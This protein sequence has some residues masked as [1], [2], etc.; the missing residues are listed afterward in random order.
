MGHRLAFKLSLP[1][2]IMQLWYNGIVTAMS[3]HPFLV[4][5]SPEI[6]DGMDHSICKDPLTL[7]QRAY[8]FQLLIISEM[9]NS[10]K[11]IYDTIN[12][13]ENMSLIRHWSLYAGYCHIRILLPVLRQSTNHCSSSPCQ[14]NVKIKPQY[15]KY[16][17]ITFKW[18]QLN[19][20]SF[21]INF[22]NRR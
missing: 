18:V 14:W 2:F 10:S 17:W 22:F 11:I 16:K 7:T 6:S 8:I 4:Y 21:L 13:F 9:C 15:I 1:L 12:K 5:Q 3:L 19:R 20:E